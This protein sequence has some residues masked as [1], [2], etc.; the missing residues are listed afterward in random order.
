MIK[1]LV[2]IVV[3]TYNEEKNIHTLLESCLL[4]DYKNLE[5]IVVDSVRT[6]DK[7]SDIAKES[8][9]KVYKHGAERS[10]QRNYG[11]SKAR[12]EYVVILDADMKLSPMVISE[13]VNTQCDAVIIPEKSYGE[14]FWAKCKALERNCYIGDSEIEAS[15]FFRKS[16]FLKAGGYN[17]DMISGEDWDLHKRIAKICK[18]GR[19]ST[20]IL[21]NEGKMSLL[22]DLKKKIYYSQKSDAYIQ[23]NVSGFKQVFLYIFRPA[24][25]RNWKL[26]LEDPVHFV[27]F[28]VMK[29]F[30]FFVGG[31]VIVSKPGFWRKIMK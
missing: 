18:V 29:F 30:E 22:G 14:S 7:T 26:L 3:A 15:R 21:H 20:H 23:E 17:Q 13:C 10:V 11:V 25:F 8:S 9:V 16:L 27:G 31:M 28:L 6:T 24:Y 2:S 12:G 5:V 1:S 4:Q 19:I